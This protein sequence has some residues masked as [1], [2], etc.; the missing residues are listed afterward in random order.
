MHQVRYINEAS[1]MDWL[2]YLSLKVI[3]YFQG[4]FLKNKNESSIV[5]LNFILLL[6]FDLK[7]LW[8]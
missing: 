8:G 6:Y 2:Q 5:S 1:N 4:M 7:K 3:C